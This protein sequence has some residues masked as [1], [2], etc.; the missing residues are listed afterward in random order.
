MIDIRDCPLD[1]LVFVDPWAGG[2]F[3]VKRVG[4]NYSWLC[5]EGFQPPDAM[6]Q[7]PYGDLVLEDEY[8]SIANA[9]PE[10]KTAVYSIIKGV[11]CCDWNVANGG[12]AA[13]G[14]N[15]T[16][17]EQGKA[18]LLKELPFLSIESQ[19]GEG[20]GNPFFAASCTLRG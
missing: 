2:S 17:L 3:T 16:W 20:F 8:R 6:C 7:G 15:L 10:P 14:E 1:T 13:V 12:S 5:Q 11:P 9:D 19:Y 18:P 4:T